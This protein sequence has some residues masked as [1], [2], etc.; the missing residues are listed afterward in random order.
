MKKINRIFLDLD[1]SI[2]HSFYISSDK[3]LEDFKDWYG[4]FDHIDFKV[5]FNERI[6]TFLRPIAYELIHECEKLVGEEE[7]Y[8][9]TAATLDYANYI[10][11][12]HGLG[13]DINR[14]Y[15]REDWSWGDVEAFLEENSNNILIDNEDYW[16]HSMGSRNKRRFIN[17]E[18]DN[19]IQIGEFNVKFKEEHSEEREQEELDRV[20]TLLKTRLQ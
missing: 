20:L 2:I 9:L 19:L 4:C 15:A 12:N 7:L 13:I 10:N 5:G 11:A 14:I 6:I 8:I 3:Q 18:H 16:Y 17:L 1:E